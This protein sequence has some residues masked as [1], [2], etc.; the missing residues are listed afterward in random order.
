LLGIFWD[1]FHRR[2]ITK[3]ANTEYEIAQPPQSAGQIIG[4]I[5]DFRNCAD[6]GRFP[7][8]GGTPNNKDK[9]C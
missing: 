5:G 6:I 7:T 8:M 9:E 4:R 3:T 2:A 1:R